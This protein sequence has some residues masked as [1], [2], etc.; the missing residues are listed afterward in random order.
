VS[1]SEKR[2]WWRRVPMFS[3]GG[4]LVRA[5]ILIV[6]WAVAHGCGLRADVCVLSGTIPGGGRGAALGGVV[7]LVSYFGAVLV[8]PGLAIAAGLWLGA[9]R[10]LARALARRASSGADA[11]NVGARASKPAR[12][13]SG[14]GPIDRATGLR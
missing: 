12:V 11:A 1:E 6:A 4:F 13:A 3:P 7:Y 2:G 14:H 10:V 9:R 5:G 8:A